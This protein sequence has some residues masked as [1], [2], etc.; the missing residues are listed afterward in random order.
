[1]DAAEWVLALFLTGL[2][3]AL[4]I[5]NA[6]ATRRLWASAMYEPPQKIA[7]T[8]LVW[9]VPG[10]VVVVW[11]LLGQARSRTHGR[12]GGAGIAENGLFAWVLGSSPGANSGARGG[13]HH[14][15]HH[16][17]G[18]GHHGDGSGSHFGGDHGG[19]GGGD[20][21]HGGGGF[22]GGGGGD[23]GQF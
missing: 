2:A 10:S 3:I 21:G 7:Q 11:N 12:S 5:A 8:V 20:G 14:A 9:L 23:G 22:D 1:M 4:V 15:G 17:S 18:S 6:L 16:D 13:E 19:Y